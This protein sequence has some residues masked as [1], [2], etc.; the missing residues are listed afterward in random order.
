MFSSSL[1]SREGIIHLPQGKKWESRL[2]KEKNKYILLHSF[3][4]KFLKLKGQFKRLE[5][6][7]YL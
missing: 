7:M 5:R 4:P 6:I 2:G 1:A 3:I